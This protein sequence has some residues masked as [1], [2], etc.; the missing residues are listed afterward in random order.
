M[1]KVVPTCVN[2]PPW[3]FKKHS[4]PWGTSICSTVPPGRQ[5]RSEMSIIICETQ[6]F[7]YFLK[8]E[9]ILFLFPPLFPLAIFFGP[10]PP[11][12][13]KVSPPW[14]RAAVPRHAAQPH[15]HASNCTPYLFYVKNVDFFLAWNI[16]RF[17][18][19]DHWALF[20][21]IAAFRWVK[22]GQFSSPSS[23][24]GGIPHIGVATYPFLVKRERKQCWTLPW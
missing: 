2:D 16:V 13:S 24:T 8:I 21:C 23:R 15:T 20:R 9:Q 10:H 12:G 4:S 14:L 19:H 1:K 7:C 5:K 22:N 11:A 6:F 17:C 18:T 3:R